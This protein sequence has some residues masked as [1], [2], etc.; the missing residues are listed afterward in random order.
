MKLTRF[1]G[2]AGLG[3][4]LSL[5]ASRSEAQVSLGADAS[6]FSSYVWRGLTLSGKPVLQP[7]LYLTAPIGPTSLTVGGWSNIELGKY[8]PPDISESNG[9]ASFD[10]TEFDWWAELAI[11]AGPATITPGATGYIYPNPK[12]SSLIDETSNTTEIYAKFALS[13]FLSPKLNVYYDVD[14]IKGAY[15]EASVSHGFPLTPALPLQIGALA[16]FSA[17]QEVNNSDPNEG[18][19]FNKSG[20]TH[21]DFS[22]SLP[23]SAGPVSITPAFHFVVNNDDFT[24]ITKYTSSGGTNSKDTKIWGGVTISWSKD[25]G[26]K[27]EE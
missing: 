20:L 24:K 7:D 1:V 8:D 21:L 16:G 2:A 23:I 19:N 10:L 27:T 3:L 12:G 15:I 14:F 18:A 22:A 5:G 9:Q 17:G 11:T 25:F 6:L 26:G 4:M 13:T